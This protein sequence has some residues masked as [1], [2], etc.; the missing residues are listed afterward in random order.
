MMKP[1]NKMI[2]GLILSLTGAVQAL[3]KYAC[4]ITGSPKL[5]FIGVVSDGGLGMKFGKTYEPGK[6]RGLSGKSVI[7][8]PVGGSAGQRIQRGR[9]LVDK[10]NEEYIHIE[11]SLSEK[12]L[13]N[14]EG[15][16]RVIKV[17]PPSLKDGPDTME[18]MALNCKS[19]D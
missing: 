7:L 15:L 6:F 11:L 8:R 2:V 5:K 3:P 19:L 9:V 18:T 14:Q 13:D 17:S 16:A 12:L 4:Q 1:M 10:L